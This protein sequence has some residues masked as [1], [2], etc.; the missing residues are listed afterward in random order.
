[1]NTKAF[2]VPFYQTVSC[3]KIKSGKDVIWRASMEKQ[4][5]ND[6]YTD[7][8]FNGTLC[9]SD[10]EKLQEFLFNGVTARTAEKALE[11]FCKQYNAKKQ[12]SLKARGIGFHYLKAL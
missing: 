3:R 1:M 5:H 7:F 4:H 11:Y 9:L 6:A 8:Q 10:K 2:C 12:E